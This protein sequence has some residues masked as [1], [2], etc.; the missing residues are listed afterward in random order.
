MK[1]R[2]A[3]IAASLGMVALLTVLVIRAVQLTSTPSSGGVPVKIQLRDANDKA[4]L[5]RNA[6]GDL[7]YIIHR[8]DGSTERVSPD[9]L[10][11]R[12]FVQGNGGVWSIMNVSGP[13]GFI[14]VCIGILGQVL[15]TGR[16]L[17]QWLAS[18]SVGRSVVPPLF[19][20]M[21]LGGSL[22]LLVY[23][24]WRWDL[25][26]I[27]GQAFGYTVYIRNLVLIYGRQAEPANPRDEASAAVAA[28]A[29]N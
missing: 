24:I 4:E 26:G 23:F 6:T 1:R 2:F 29:A 28:A 20:W 3:T 14:W 21:S 27:G 12:L 15:F 25:V 5:V 13:A 10:A 11:H 9:D 7:E 19:W 17:V 8:A 22:M 18:E 16:L